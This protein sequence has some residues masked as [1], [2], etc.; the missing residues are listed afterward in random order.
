MAVK[1][2]KEAD[3]EKLA[4]QTFRALT[5]VFK[6]NGIAVRREQL[7]RSRAYRVKSGSCFLKQER[8][9]FVDNRLSAVQQ[10][11]ILT[12]FLFDTKLE[13]TT[14]C[15]EALSPASRKLVENHFA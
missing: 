9:L 7:S 2:Q 5:K 14:E 3:K 6:H 13:V 1:K 15:L 12:D 11:S 10:N 4:E 8:M